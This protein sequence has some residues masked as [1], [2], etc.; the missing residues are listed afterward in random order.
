MEMMKKLANQGLIVA[1]GRRFSCGKNEW[2]WVRM[3]IAT[4]ED[5][6]D[7]AIIAI[8]AYRESYF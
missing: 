2:G 1:A 8:K 6:I 4:T 5:K 7:K 3:T